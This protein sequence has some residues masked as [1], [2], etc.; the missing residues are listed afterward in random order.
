LPFKKI[1]LTE[2]NYYNAPDKL[3][4]ADI[5]LIKTGTE[6]NK[7]LSRVF[8]QTTLTH[9]QYQKF[10]DEAFNRG[11]VVPISLKKLNSSSIGPRLTTG[12][13]KI[14]G[15]P[16]NTDKRLKDPFFS[17]V[18]EILSI[19]DEN[20][21]KEKM[22]E[23]IQIDDD[24]FDYKLKET[25]RTTFKFKVKFTDKKRASQYEA[26]LQAGQI[27]LKSETTSSASGIGGIAR[28]FINDEIIK[29]LP[30]KNKFFRHLIEIR[31]KTFEEKINGVRQ[32]NIKDIKVDY[33][34]ILPGLTYKKPALTKKG[35]ITED[36]EIAINAQK[37]IIE[38]LNKIVKKDKNDE[39]AKIQ[40]KI[41]KEN[42]KKIG[43]VP[44]LEEILSEAVKL[45]LGNKVSIQKIINS[46][47]EKLLK[48]LI[49]KIFSKSQIK[50]QTEL[51]NAVVKLNLMDKKSATLLEIGQLKEII[52]NSKTYVGLS[53][54]PALNKS[55]LLSAGSLSK[56]FAKI[57]AGLRKTIA[58][59]YVKNLCHHLGPKRNEIFTDYM[60]EFHSNSDF[61]QVDNSSGSRVSFNEITK[62]FFEKISSYEMIYLC[63][64][65]QTV[66]KNW[67]KSS[68]IMSVYAAAAAYGII[69]FNGKKHQ[70]KSGSSSYAKITRKNPVYVKIGE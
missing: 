29:N 56:I 45:G 38:N 1:S 3:T 31:K 19:S 43:R 16:N 12:L 23:V 24:S 27:Y 44:V 48:N 66:V 21:F 47:D 55:N 41:E 53:N 5:F 14:I 8:N 52:E 10:I 35:E 69:I 61:M 57:P 68:F 67:I 2:N 28:D 54:Y 36:I 65:N 58:E 50:K 17:T 4:T 46:K 63:S 70:L 49:D 20:K 25:G 30:E 33:T 60:N 22:E 15:L 37:T 9:L 13:I 39:Y 6:G 59:R 62:I 32:F 64:A 40:L 7:T 11:E 18:L 26:F 51:V 34:D 42:L